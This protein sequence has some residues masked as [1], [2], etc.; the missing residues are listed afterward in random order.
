MATTAGPPDVTDSRS[1]WIA[2][3]SSAALIG[4]IGLLRPGVALRATLIL[5]LVVAVL[6]LVQT[7]RQLFARV[8]PVEDSVIA[9]AS[10]PDPA[11]MN[12]HELPWH[13]SGLVPSRTGNPV[14]APG[15][16]TAL[17][18]IATERLWARHHLNVWHPPHE[19]AIGELLSDRL[20][21]VINPNQ[22]TP[23]PPD[24][25]HHAFLDRHLDELDAL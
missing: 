20:W 13:Y 12:D 16:R 19:V 1:W 9:P 2:G 4:S 7:V 25:F 10:D 15:T 5:C 18:T 3:I 24:A 8:P 11:T 6:A 21:A 17:R 22:R 23:P 14:L